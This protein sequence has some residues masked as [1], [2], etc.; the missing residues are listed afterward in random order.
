MGA[1]VAPVVV[2]VFFAF[3]LGSGAAGKLPWA[4]PAWYAASSAITY[5]A[6][7]VDKAAAVHGTWRTSERKLHALALAGG[8]P[9][10]LVAQ[11]WLCHKSTKAAF[12]VPFFVSVGLNLA[13]LAWLAQTGWTL[14]RA[15][16]A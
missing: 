7:R 3:L 15:G 2:L 14:L 10:A 6:Y 8:W 16:L 1:I 11:R 9:G 4:V 12:L 13:A 5:L